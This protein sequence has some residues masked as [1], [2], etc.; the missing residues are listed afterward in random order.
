MY[1]KKLL[2]ILAVITALTVSILFFLVFLP[3]IIPSLIWCNYVAKREEKKFLVEYKQFLKE[4][5][6][7][8]FF[9]YT[10]RQN[11]QNWIEDRILPKLNSNIEIVFLDG[12]EPKT[13]LARKYISHSL[14][15]IKNVGFPSV[16]KIVNGQMVDSSLHD[17]LYETINQNLSDQIF[18]EELKNKLESLDQYIKPN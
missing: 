8:E 10:S 11:S 3:I 4:H 2:C 1:F 9:C 18:L 14:Y 12:K 16:M 5:E 15:H 6:G 17:K 13:K 7:Q